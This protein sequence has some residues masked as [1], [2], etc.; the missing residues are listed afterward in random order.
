MSVMEDT[1]KITVGGTH[2]GPIYSCAGNSTISY[3]ESYQV[4]NTLLRI[5][6]LTCSVPAMAPSGFGPYHG[7]WLE[8]TTTK[9][10]GAIPT[11]WVMIFALGFVRFPPQ[12]RV[13][14]AQHQTFGGYIDRDGGVRARIKVPKSAQNI[15]KNQDGLVVAMEGSA[16]GGGADGGMTTTNNRISRL[17]LNNILRIQ[18][19]GLCGVTIV[20]GIG[21]PHVV[22]AGIP[23]VEVWGILITERCGRRQQR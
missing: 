21:S 10:I 13:W 22:I 8:D 1:R 6:Y 15:F 4:P 16:V 23:A 14:T 19:Q 2:L 7:L 17:S 11:P 20:G 18:G 3:V 9:C 5:N 12:P